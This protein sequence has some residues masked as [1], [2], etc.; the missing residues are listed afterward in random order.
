V[1]DPKFTSDERMTKQTRRTFAGGQSIL[2]SGHANPG[3][4][5][6][7][8]TFGKRRKGSCQGFTLQLAEFRASRTISLA[9]APEDRGDDLH[10]R[11]DM[12]SDTCWRLGWTFTYV[13]SFPR[14]GAL[15]IAAPAG[16]LVGGPLSGSLGAGPAGV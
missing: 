4:P 9:D 15:A 13:W 16:S 10:W 6:P 8:W 1:A 7:I 12:K 5:P 14:D 3:S 2:G 11:N